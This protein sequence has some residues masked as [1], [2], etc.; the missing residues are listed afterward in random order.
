LGSTPK[1]AKLRL[2]A[3]LGYLKVPRPVVNGTARVPKGTQ[4]R[5]GGSLRLAVLLGYLKVPGPVVHGNLLDGRA[6]R[7]PLKSD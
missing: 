7:L 5:G 1:A 2:M 6:F 4:A 3:L